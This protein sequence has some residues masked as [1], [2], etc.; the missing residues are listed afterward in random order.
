M[1][2]FKRIVL[3]FVFASCTSGIAGQTRDAHHTAA[4]PSGG[5]AGC[6]DTNAQEAS[7]SSSSASAASDSSSHGYNL[8]NLDRSVSP[9]DDFFQFADGGWIKNN[10]IPSTHPSWG[11]S[12]KLQQDNIDELRLILEDAAKDK[13]ATAGSNW[14]KIGDYYAS[15]MNEAQVE[16]AGLTPLDAEFKLIAAIKNRAGLETEMARLQQR[17]VNAVFRFGADSDAK[18]SDQIIGQAGQGGL[19]LPESEYYL[20]DDEKSQQLRV[21]YVAHVTKMFKLL[22]DDDAT[23]AKEAKIVKDVETSLAK[24]SMNP[25]DIRNPDKTYH[26]MTLAEVHQL[27]PHFGWK[28][29]LRDVGAPGVS[30]FNVGQP[31][32][33]KHV[34]L[35]LTS[36]SIADWQTY[37][38]WHL[39]NAAASALTEKLVAENFDFYGRTLTGSEENL[40]RWQRCVQSTDNQLGEA[41]GQYYVQRYFPPEAKAKALAMVQNLV[42]ALRADLSTL[43]WMSPA[44]RQKAIE[45]LDTLT[46]K[47]GYP[48]KWRDYSKYDVNRGPYAANYFDGNV[49]EFNR[50]IAKIGKP[51]DRTEW[52][53]TPP[54]VNAENGSSWNEIVFP[55][56]IL[57]PPLFDPLRDDALN[58]GDMGGVIGHEMTHSFDNAGAKYD[59]HG[60]LKNWWTPEDLKNFQE[61]GKCIVKQFDAF[62]VEPGLHE[63][64][65][66]EEGESIADL[67]G[68]VIAYAAYHKSLEG[69]PEPAPI[70]GFTADQRFFLAY[71][72]GWATQFRPEYA[73]LLANTNEHPLDKFRAVGPPSNMPEFAK[74]FQCSA[75]APMVRA[76]AER[77]RIW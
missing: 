40:P 2:G 24:S 72:E 77:C 69:K 17:G 63:N 74:A 39:L 73:R 15:C 27:M 21:A 14:Q 71:A 68:L 43:D 9:C 34:D 18:D 47:I 53:M 4:L 23:A 67:G 37:L 19:G 1:R 38:R 59:A 22:G 32:F 11:V 36:T 10:P 49:F 60:N 3:G 56:G 26:K 61:R 52:D 20:R 57:Q 16:S 50:N 55:A 70:D 28:G 25:V 46:L 5:G 51:V 64:G 6:I 13:N 35:V 48:D 29:F 12:D 44:T 41:L 75:K 76:E 45:K 8:A 66:L 65:E 54:T 31:D 30:S 58:Y 33:F 42:A 7:S 62:E